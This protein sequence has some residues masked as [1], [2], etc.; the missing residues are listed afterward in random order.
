MDVKWE[1]SFCS[2]PHSF[3]KKPISKTHLKIILSFMGM[4]INNLGGAQ[5]KWRKNAT[6]RWQWA[7]LVAAIVQCQKGPSPGKN[8]FVSDFP[9]TPTPQSVMVGP[10][11]SGPYLDNVN[12]QSSIFF[13]EFWNQI[14]QAKFGMSVHIPLCGDTHTPCVKIINKATVSWFLAWQSD[15]CVLKSSDRKIKLWLTEFFF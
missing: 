15:R 10:Y 11:V 4:T 6:W 7:L 8:K 9:S 13:I 5:R 12:C 14:T 1:I 3:S 2:W